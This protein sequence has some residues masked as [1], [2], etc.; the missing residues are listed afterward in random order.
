MELVLKTEPFL[1]TQFNAELSKLDN[2]V[3]VD[4]EEAER[5]KVYLGV[6]NMQ[7]GEMNLNDDPLS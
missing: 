4:Q 3:P 5:L 1:N 6:Y 7:L 2:M